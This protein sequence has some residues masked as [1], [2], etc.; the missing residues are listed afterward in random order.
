MGILYDKE[1]LSALSLM[2][3]RLYAILLIL[4]IRALFGLLTTTPLVL[5][6]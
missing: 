1:E 6:S 2:F 4:N 5:Q 3:L